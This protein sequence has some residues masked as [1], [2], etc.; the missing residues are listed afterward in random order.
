[1]LHFL[2]EQA[3]LIAQQRKDFEAK[4]AQQQKQIEALIA[5]VQKVSDRLGLEKAVTQVVAND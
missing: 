4:I 2:E 1:M 5:T 3:T